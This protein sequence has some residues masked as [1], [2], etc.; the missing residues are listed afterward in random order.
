MSVKNKTFFSI[1]VPAYNAGKDIHKTIDSVLAQSFDNWELIIVDDCSTDNTKDVV[2]TYS[3]KN[4]NIKYT[5]LEKNS[6]NAKKPRDYGVSISK[7]DYCV[8]LDSDDALS[9]D[10][11]EKIHNKI[12]SE[13]ADVVIS[14]MEM[15]ELETK[16]LVNILPRQDF[17]MPPYGQDA[18]KYILSSWSFSGGGIAFCRELYKYVNDLNPYYYCYSD[19]MSERILVYYAKKVSLSSG[20]YTYWQHKDSIT[21]KC[22]PKLFEMLN[23]DLNLIEFTKKRYGQ[24]EVDEVCI[25]TLRHMLS[26]Y[27]KYL[28]NYREFSTDICSNI[29]SIFQ[30]AYRCLQKINWNK[31][32]VKQRVYMIN[33]MLFKWI[34]KCMF[35]IKK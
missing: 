17:T 22:S 29:E 30:T 1:I 9:E 7:G 15:R 4:P 35:L 33:F 24:D 3:E 10:Y 14:V 18:C 12:I 23:V 28:Q 31:K 25:S 26:L 8:M 27:K 13:Q 21:H 11:L 20:V 34:N 5:S 16:A 19:E 32:G 2:C 6:G